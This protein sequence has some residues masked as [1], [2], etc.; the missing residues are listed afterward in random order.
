MPVF[1]CPK[2]Q[3]R[4]YKSKN[5]NFPTLKEQ[6]FK[7]LPMQAVILAAGRG[8]RL[9]PITETRTKAMAP[10][11]G[12]PIVER[13]MEPLIAHGIQDFIL[14][15][16]PDDDSVRQ[17]FHSVNLQNINICLVEQ[18]EPLGM[19]H[20]LMQATA[21]IWEDFVLSSCDNLV[22]WDDIESMLTL[23]ETESRP[24]A[25][26]SLLRVPPEMIHRVGIVKLAG[27]RVVEI[28]EKPDPQKAPSNI[29]STPL[30]CF[31][32]EFLEL[33]P[34][35]KPSA[36]GEY[37]LQSAIQMLIQNDGHVRG[38]PISNRIDLTTPDDLLDINMMYFSRHN[39]QRYLAINPMDNGTQLIPPYHIEAGVR[40]GENCKIGPNAFIERD[41]LIADGVQLENSVVLR[42]REVKEGIYRDQVVY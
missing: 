41:C 25:L 27:D 28:I 21:H 4:D 3:A 13:V 38:H 7:T 36:R 31:R 33:L 20:A 24:Q 23:W 16:S 29:A 35:V 14:V 17:Y 26:L 9:H 34:K 11:M 32:K 39:Q 18:P 19:A 42:E 22:P 2:F 6:V 5:I 12:K 10:I 15:I 37:E 30:Y 40:L 1:S 8:K